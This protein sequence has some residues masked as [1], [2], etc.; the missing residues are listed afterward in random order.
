MISI[1]AVKPDLTGV[2]ETIGSITTS[3]GTM[4]LELVGIRVVA[5]LRSLTGEMRPPAK[6]GG[7]V[8]RAHPGHWADISGDL[9][10]S[11]WW[12]IEEHAD[13]TVLAIGNSSGHAAFV[14]AR[15]GFF[16]ISGVMDRGGPVAE[17]IRDIAPKVAPGWKV[18]L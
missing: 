9:A 8:R 11:Y 5:Y 2:M 3:Q 6:T 1:E 7:P 16:V 13:G 10:R 18:Q 14:E 17:A 4:V 12:K 15:D